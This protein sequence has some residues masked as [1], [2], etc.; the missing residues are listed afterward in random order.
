MDR[1]MTLPSQAGARILVVDD[2]RQIR[3]LLCRML[4]ALGYK[5]EEA[6]RRDEALE[7]LRVSMYDLVLLDVDLPD[8]AGHDVLDEVRSDPSSRLLPVIM[9]TGS[10]GR[11]D[12]LR[13]IRSGVTDFVIKPF[14]LEEIATR[15][16]ALL[17]LK[18]FTDALEEAEKVIVA[19]AKTIDARDPYTAGHSE[20]VSF[21]AGLLGQRMG[22]NETDL[23]ALRQ[24]ALFHDLGKIAV[25]DEVLLKPDK[26]TADEYQHMKCHPTVGRDLLRH[27]KTLPRALPVVYH[28]H[29]KLDGSGYPDGINGSAIPV[30]T[31][32]VSIA[33]VYDALTTDRPYRPALEREQALTIMT[34]E[35]R[36][37][38]WDS[39]VLD[40]FRHLLETLPERDPV[41]A[42]A[43]KGQL[44]RESV[45]GK[46]N[47]G[48]TFGSAR[49]R[50]FTPES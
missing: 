36:K 4:L 29:E 7:R 16:R 21:Y 28:H 49:P 31:R 20:R 30:S 33:D 17:Q 9:I 45:A 12:R 24:G 47:G 44:Q 34:G 35:A 32:I 11:D 26:L 18:F 1:P 41:F 37:G 19:L 25:R 22:L 40:E 3:G 2:D 13:A 23:A 5:V 6:A 14:D 50:A 48:L 39:D 38:W 8:G 15:V 27:M 43:E 10:G 42:A 46:A